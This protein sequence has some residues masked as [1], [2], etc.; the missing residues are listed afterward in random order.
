CLGILSANKWHEDLD[1]GYPNM[2]LGNLLVS[3]AL[4]RACGLRECACQSRHSPSPR[5]R[6]K[7]STAAPLIPRTRVHLEQAAPSPSG[8]DF[9]ARIP[10][11]SM[12]R[13]RCPMSQQKAERIRALN[14]ALRKS[15]LD[16]SLGKV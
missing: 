3:A 7:P 9:G 10:R 11:T 1:N 12:T 14:D 4:V 16:R 5:C 8:S 2:A 6:K 13:R 15:P